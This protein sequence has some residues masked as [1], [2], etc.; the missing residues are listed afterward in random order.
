MKS[1]LLKAFLTTL[2]VIVFCELVCS[3]GLWWMGSEIT[4][5][6]LIMT[7][8]LPALTVFP[9]ALF[10][11]VQNH[12]LKVTLRELKLAHQQ[13]QAKSRIDDMTG[14][15]NRGSFFEAMKISRS[16]VETGAALAIDADRFKS[17]NDTYGH[18]IGDRALKIIAFALQN[19]TRKGDI[20]GRIGGEEFCIFL[21]GASRE[22]ALRL[23]ERVRAE[24]E[25]TPL[26][27]AANQVHP[28]TISIGCAVAFKHESNSQVLSRADKCL[29]RAKQRGRNCV[30]YD[31][32]DEPTA[33]HLHP[34]QTEG[35]ERDAL[36][37]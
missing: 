25:N 11:F 18:A 23:A 26:Y 17:I 9:I 14:L 32:G 37:S 6:P 13:L 15:L 36:G 4:L 21:P 24:V 33:Y 31:D 35:N 10:S 7:A 5:F 27:T 20:V 34:R 12:R 30:V 29:Y 22:T 16:R 1:A 28:L 3:A 2:A 8:V 19:V